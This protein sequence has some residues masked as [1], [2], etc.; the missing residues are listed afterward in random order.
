[1]ATAASDQGDL[2]FDAPAA[3]ARAEE[4]LHHEPDH[5]RSGWS[6]FG[7]KPRAQTAYAPVH[8]SARPHPQPELRPTQQTA[9]EPAAAEDDLEIPSFLRRLAN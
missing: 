5:R 2:Y 6:L 8:Q 1:V 3:P 4:P 9:P 7:K